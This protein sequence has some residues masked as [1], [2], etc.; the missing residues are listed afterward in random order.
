MEGKEKA[1]YEEKFIVINTDHIKKMNKAFVGSN[2][3]ATPEHPACRQLRQAVI[4]FQVVYYAEFKHELHKNNYYV[5]NQD[6]PY[7]QK[8]IDTIL[9]G[10]AEKEPAPFAMPCLNCGKPVEVAKEGYE[11]QGVFNVFCPGGECEDTYAGG[12]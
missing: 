4:D 7:S 3:I 10:E 12:L 2:A 6:E 1:K 9:E 8:V 5:C 11:A